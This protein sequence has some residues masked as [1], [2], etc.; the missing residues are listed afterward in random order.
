MISGELSNCSNYVKITG[1]SQIG[2]IVGAIEEGTV[3]NCTNYGDLNGEW[4]IGGIAGRTGNAE[5]TIRIENCMSVAKIQGK[6]LMGGIIGENFNNAT[7]TD[8]SNLGDIISMGGIADEEFDGKTLVSLVG[9]I[10]G[11]NYSI[12]SRCIN[13]GTIEAKN[14]TNGGIA[15]R[16]FGT[17]SYCCNLGNVKGESVIG[18]IVGN[19][20]GN[21]MYVYNIAQ[22]IEALASDGQTGGIA[23]NQTSTTN[24]YIQYS[25]NSAKV[26]GDINNIGGIIG[27]VGIGTLDH[28]YNIGTINNDTSVGTIYGTTYSTS[29]ITNSS[30]LT[31]SAMKEWNQSTI[32]TNLGQFVKKENSLPILNI[33]VRGGITF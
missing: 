32:T 27:G 1:N 17:V 7:I 10:T 8:C 2:G 31:E 15:G 25:Y 9:G 28:L 23:G 33:T 30:K 22:E 13:K 21:I 24:A 6:Y 20:R 19:N 12:I 26:V 3:S 16:N 18:G 11:R 4:R 5:N 14:K 29:V